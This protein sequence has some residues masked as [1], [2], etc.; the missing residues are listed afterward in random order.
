MSGHGGMPHGGG[1]H[2]SGV[3]APTPA[4]SELFFLSEVNIWAADLLELVFSAPTKNNVMLRDPASY[5]ML[6]FDGGIPVT[7]R[8]VRSGLS[9]TTTR[10]FLVITPATQGGCYDVSVIGDVRS[11]YDN[12]LQSPVTQRVKVHRTKVDSMLSGRPQMYDI[13]AEALYRNVLNAIG[14]QDHLIG[15]NILTCEED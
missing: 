10:A 13:R 9:V 4:E 15:G 1:P 8:A 5:N 2:G 14:Y 7:I 11:A 6:P 12:A 3:A